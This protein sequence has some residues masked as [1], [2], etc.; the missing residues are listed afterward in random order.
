MKGY[1]YLDDTATLCFNN[2][3][4]TGCGNCLVVCPHRV[5]SLK[6]GKAEVMDPNW[7]M[8]CGACAVNCPA[9]A[10]YVRAGVGCAQA[11]LHGW[12]SRVPLLRRVFSPDACCS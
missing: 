8:E 1:R 9:G 3:L 6:N 5:F 4:C 11:I 12:L 10:I 2:N 7:C